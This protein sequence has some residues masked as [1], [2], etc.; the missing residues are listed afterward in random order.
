M[1]PVDLNQFLS[2]VTLM[3]AIIGLLLLIVVPRTD[4]YARTRTLG[5]AFFVSGL[6]GVAGLFLLRSPDVLRGMQEHIA[7]TLIGMVIATLSVIQ[8][9]RR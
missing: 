3:M 6:G 9:L 4:Y 8:L 5:I 7:L 1:S 2:V